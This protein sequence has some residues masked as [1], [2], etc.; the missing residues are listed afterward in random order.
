MRWFFRLRQLVKGATRSQ[1]SV[2]LLLATA[3]TA[4]VSQSF[5][6]FGRVGQCDLSTSD[7]KI[8]WPA[9]EDTN[10]RIFDTNMTLTL[11]LTDLTGENLTFDQ[12]ESYFTRAECPAGTEYDPLARSCSPCLRTQYGTCC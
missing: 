8:I 12:F 7:L 4:L 5:Q 1:A 6:A 2:S 3:E 11:S 10:G 9:T